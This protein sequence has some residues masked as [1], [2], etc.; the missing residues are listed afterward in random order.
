MLGPV[1][2]RS[3]GVWIALEKPSNSAQV[4]YWAKGADKSKAMEAWR[5]NVHSNE[6]APYHIQSFTLTDLEPG[7]TYEYEVSVS[8]K[9]IVNAL[10]AAISKGEVTTQHLFQWRMNA[11]DFTFLTGSCA[12]FNQPQ[13]DRPGKPYGLDSSIFETMAKEKAAFMLWLGDNWY[14]REVDYS[15]KWGLWYRAMHDRSQPILKDFWKAMPHLAIWDDHDFG[16]NDY[17]KSYLLKNTSRDVFNAMWMNPTSGESN[18]GIYTRYTY[19]DVDFFMLD[20]RWWR[21]FDRLPDSVNGKPND[22]KRMYGKRQMEWLKNDLR[23][24]K[25]NPFI[26]F[27]IIATGSQVINPGSPFDKLLDFPVEYN[28]LI[29]FIRDEKIDGVVFLSGDRHHSEVIKVQHEG[30]YPLYDITCSPLTS[31]THPFGGKEANNPWRVIGV[32]KLQNFG[33]LSISGPRSNRVLKV[34]FAGLKGEKLAEWQVGE[35]ELRV[36]SK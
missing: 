6:G 17:G 32:D 21:S 2:L 5:L 25:T 10:P 22:E 1:S 12:Y 30:L 27:R 18:E 16:P 33:R 4:K 14:T 34:E 7:T 26:S 29:N 24:S 20:D 35:Q 15:S 19:S 8:D 28:E 23:Y 9:N 3:A 13:Y 36:K 31:G 11:P